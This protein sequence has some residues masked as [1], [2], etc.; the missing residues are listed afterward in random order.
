MCLLKGTWANTRTYTSLIK[1]LLGCLW[2]RCDQIPGGL[3]QESNNYC[4]QTMMSFWLSFMHHHSLSYIEYLLRLFESCYHLNWFIHADSPITQ[5]LDWNQHLG[6]PSLG[7]LP[8]S[9]GLRGSWY[10]AH[11]C[12][13]GAF[14]F[15]SIG[16]CWRMVIDDLVPTRPI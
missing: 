8:W 4:T 5:V 6:L 7:H 13:R 9:C 2:I 14:A 12:W 10:D 16:R 15:L 1:L 3:D 11:C